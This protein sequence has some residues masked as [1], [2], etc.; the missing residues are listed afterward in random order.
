MGIK[1]VCNRCFGGFSI[2]RKCAEHMAQLGSEEA[3]E[4]LKI[5]VED[6]YWHAGWDGD[7]HDPIL[8]KAVLELGPDADGDCADLRVVEL[9]GDR[10]I[11]DEYDGIESVVEPSDINWIV[12][13][14]TE[15]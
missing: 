6:D 9:E 5:V 12:V 11:I 3:K 8:V 1:V 4:L 14:S 15:K 2:S 10:Y 7:R 13:Q